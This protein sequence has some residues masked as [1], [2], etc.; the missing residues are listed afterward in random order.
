MNFVL[1]VHPEGAVKQTTAA[2]EAKI[3]FVAATRHITEQVGRLWQEPG[4]N[5]KTRMAWIDKCIAVSWGVE[6]C[7]HMEG[8]ALVYISIHTLAEGWK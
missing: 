6:T 2:L 3:A 4:K 7:W 5:V 1:R 8:T